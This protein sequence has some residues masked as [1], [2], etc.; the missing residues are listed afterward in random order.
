[1]K[2]FLT[3]ILSILLLASCNVV[4]TTPAQPEFGVMVVGLSGRWHNVEENGIL[5]AD[6][7]LDLQP[8]ADQKRYKV[9]LHERGREE[10]VF[11]ILLSPASESGGYW[12]F[13]QDEELNGEFLLFH[14]MVKEQEAVFRWLDAKKTES[15]LASAGLPVE[16]NRDTG[17][18]SFS[19]LKIH[20]TWG[21]LLDALNAQGLDVLNPDRTRL[22]RSSSNG[23]KEPE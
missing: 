19:I 18:T 7:Y 13:T 6:E 2:V 12:G 16:M 17:I 5:S 22:R 21:A 11:Q 4:V 3:S 14:L 9:V 8:I 1:M 20:A 10:A 23:G 15:L